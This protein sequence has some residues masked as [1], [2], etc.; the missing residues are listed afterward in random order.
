MTGLIEYSFKSKNSGH[1]TLD[2]VAD[3]SYLRAV[4]ENGFQAAKFVF[5]LRCFCD[6]EVDEL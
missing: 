6:G 4:S 2:E 3:Q 1:T 5:A